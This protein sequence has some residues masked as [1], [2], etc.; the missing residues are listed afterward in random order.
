MLRRLNVISNQFEDPIKQ[1][2]FLHM[3]LNYF[4]S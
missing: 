4:N 2:E 1:I 3:Y